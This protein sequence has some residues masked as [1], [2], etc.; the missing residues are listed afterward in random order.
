MAKPTRR[1]L[2]AGAAALA[3]APV[4]AR[5]AGPTLLLPKS[6]PPVAVASANGHQFKN[7]GERTAIEEAFARLVA[8]SDPLDAV[9]AGVA[10]NEL[11][12]EDDSVGYGGKPNADGVVQL[13]ASVMHGPRRR[14]GAVAALEGVRTASAVAKA[15][16]DLTDHHLLVGAGARE[17]ARQVGFTIEDD[18]NT[19]KSRRQ[20]LEWKRKIDPEHWLDPARRESAAEAARRAMVAEA[21]VDPEHLWGT[22]H[23][24]VLSPKGE[25]A[26]ATTTCGLAWK[27]PGRVGDSAILGAGLWVDGEVGAAGST[28]RGE[29][30]LYNLSCHLIVEELRRGAHPKDAAIEA[31]RRVRANSL[32]PRLLNADGNPA[33]D[34]KFYAVDR[35]G[36]YAGVSLYGIYK[37]R[38]TRFATATGQG[39]EIRAMDY[40]LPECPAG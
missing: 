2:L 12:P 30:N 19:E 32:E 34:L 33:F 23:L 24:S 5:S 4:F 25:L 17:F 16:A 27:I 18:L 35:L 14:A 20:W 37:G 36:R 21:G 39:A 11:D 6:V 40:L 38:E 1:E 26:G 15:V 8:G 28:G 10:L 22:I 9:L 3:G 29:A 7:G 31:L 13:D